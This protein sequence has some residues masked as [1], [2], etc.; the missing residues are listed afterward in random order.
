M[1]P[2]TGNG[3]AQ[4]ATGSWKKRFQSFSLL[5]LASMRPLEPSGRCS[6]RHWQSEEKVPDFQL[7]PEIQRGFVTAPA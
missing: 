2:W 4:L 7:P 6:A 5:S 1:K 3:D